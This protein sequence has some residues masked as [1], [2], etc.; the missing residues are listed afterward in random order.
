MK[1]SN[2]DWTQSNQNLQS[3]NQRVKQLNDDWTQSNQNLQSFNQ[4]MKLRE[5]ANKLKNHGVDFTTM[6]AEN[7]KMSFELTEKLLKTTV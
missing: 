4:R 6:D 1:Q 3:F 2:D 5:D 7:T